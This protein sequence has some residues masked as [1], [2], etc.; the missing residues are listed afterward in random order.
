M[1]NHSLNAFV[2]AVVALG[3][4]DLA[5]ALFAWDGEDLLFL[6]AL[7]VLVAV[8]E[9]FD[10]GPFRGSRISI[11]MTAVLAAGTF[12]GLPGAAL[13]ALAI[14]GMDYVVHRKPV[15]KAAFNFGAIA[16]AGAAH[17][18][19]LEALSSTYDSGD[20]VAMIAPVTAG[21][22]AAFAV[23]SALVAAVISLNGSQNIISTWSSG[24]RW[25]LPYYILMGLLALSLAAAYDR[26]ELGGLA[27]VMVPLA[28][29]WLA[30]RDH[31]AHPPQHTSTAAS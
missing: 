29:I 1:K 23:N 16:L 12:A 28:A 20:W 30:L 26:W 2:A 17:V 27:V 11:S 5:S 7:A 10:F 19:V 18:G 3:I 24:F 21:S 4:A 13:L 6:L 15:V 14:A 9:I 31:L 8:S 25:L 22:L